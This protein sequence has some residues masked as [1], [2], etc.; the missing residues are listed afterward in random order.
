MK[1]SSDNL[2]K[3]SLLIVKIYRYLALG[4]VTKVTIIVTLVYTLSS[5][6]SGFLRYFCYGNLRYF[7]N[8]NLL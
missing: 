4:N 1:I 8:D 2:R 3:L 7:C 6:M 5:R